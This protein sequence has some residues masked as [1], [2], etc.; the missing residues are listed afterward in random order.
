M[1]TSNIQ[2]NRD[3][4]MTWTKPR[5]KLYLFIPA[6]LLLFLGCI[7]VPLSETDDSSSVINEGTSMYSPT[8]PGVVGEG[9]VLPDFVDVVDLSLIHI[10]EPTRP[11]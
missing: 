9:P 8:S 10:S 6:F 7:S 4:H 3:L 11:Y 2:N 1:R 5:L